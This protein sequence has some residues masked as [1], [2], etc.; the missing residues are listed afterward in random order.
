MKWDKVSRGKRK[1]EEEQQKRRIYQKEDAY[2]YCLRS[3]GSKED[4]GVKE[5]GSKNIKVGENG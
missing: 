1:S 4:I 5:R 3:V 2:N